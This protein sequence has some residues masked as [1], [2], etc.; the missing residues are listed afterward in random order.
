MAAHATVERV[1]RIVTRGVRDLPMP[2]AVCHN[3]RLRTRRD[4]FW[5]SSMDADSGCRSELLAFGFLL[6]FL[7]GLVLGLGLAFLKWFPD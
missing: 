5:I 3:H 4:G 7:L 6:L 2:W 1:R